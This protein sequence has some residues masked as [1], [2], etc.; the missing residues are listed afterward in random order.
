VDQT[1][2]AKIFI[3]LGGGTASGQHATDEIYT[4]MLCSCNDLAYLLTDPVDPERGKKMKMEMTP[5]R[6]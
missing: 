4:E 5:W 6:E 1:W 2:D 3:L